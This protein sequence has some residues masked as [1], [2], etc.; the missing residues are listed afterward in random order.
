[1]KQA[2]LDYR[3]AFWTERVVGTGRRLVLDMRND[4]PRRF[5]VE[6]RRTFNTRSL[7]T[8]TALRL[9]MPL[10]L[11]SDHLGNLEVEPL[12]IDTC[13]VGTQV[14]VSRGRLE[15]RTQAPSSGE[16]TIGALTTFTA[17]PTDPSRERPRPDLGV[18]DSRYLR[19]RDGLIVVS[20]RI[21]ALAHSLAAPDDDPA[22]S[23]RAF[24][25]YCLDEF[26]QGAVH[27]DQVDMEAPGD[28]LLIPVGAIVSLSRPYLHPFAGR[29][30][31]QLEY[32]AAFIYIKRAR[33]FT[34]GRKR[35]ST[36]RAGRHSI[37]SAGNYREAA[38]IWHGVIISSAGSTPA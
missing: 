4:D 3:E 20:D 30:A 10:P 37:L 29:A 17:A 13:S 33:P 15:V 1:M 32:W 22:V 31:F 14:A 19:Q 7:A 9:R 11:T 12:A 6:L 38:A 24:W 23:V 28:W 5:T 21:A 25:N 27:Y 18:P 16:V 8:G 26:S 34:F 36:A 2:G 35:G